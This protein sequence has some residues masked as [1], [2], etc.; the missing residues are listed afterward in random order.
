MT[1]RE[2]KYVND[3]HRLLGFILSWEGESMA[4]AVCINAISKHTREVLGMWQEPVVSRSAEMTVLIGLTFADLIQLQNLG[5]IEIPANP[6]GVPD[7][8]ITIF[9][10]GTDEHMRKGIEKHPGTDFRFFDSHGDAK[11]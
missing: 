5:T 10:G 8:S 9:L 3:C 11:N 4:K 1:E 2:Q 6:G 7:T